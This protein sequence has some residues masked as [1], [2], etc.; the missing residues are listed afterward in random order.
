M[1]KNGPGRRPYL[2]R[3]VYNDSSAK[4]VKLL[5]LSISTGVPL[6]HMDDAL[7]ATDLQGKTA[8]ATVGVTM[9]EEPSAPGLSSSPTCSLKALP[10]AMPLLPDLPF[11]GNPSVG[12]PFFESLASPSQ[13]KKDC[14]P[15]GPFDACHGKG[16]QIDSHEVEVRSEHSSTWGLPILM[17]GQLLA[18]QRVPEMRHPLCRKGGSSWGNVA[19]S[20]LDTA[21]EDCLS[22]LD[23]DEVSIQTTQKR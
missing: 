5:P 16:T 23:T 12:C 17:K 11:E 6:H 10:P 13:K 9:P 4:S 15:S 20:D 1:G 7:T 21:S 18:A 19:G 14:S 3:S 22:C 8:P 2:P